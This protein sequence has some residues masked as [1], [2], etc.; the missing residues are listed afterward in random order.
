MAKIKFITSKK[1]L[2]K[3]ADGTV[4]RDKLGDLFV[5]HADGLENIYF[6]ITSG[7]GGFSLKWEEVDD[8]MCRNMIFHVATD[9]K[10]N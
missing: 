5:K 6:R 7:N 10:R 1:Q 3:L 8:I 4:I 9:G 2:K